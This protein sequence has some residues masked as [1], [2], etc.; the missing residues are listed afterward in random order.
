MH[1]R[2][3]LTFVYFAAYAGAPRHLAVVSYS[4]F[5]DIMFDTKPRKY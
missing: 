3:S 2:V 4:F 5:H 1:R